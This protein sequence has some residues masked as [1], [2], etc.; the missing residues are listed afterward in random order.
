MT[1]DNRQLPHAEVGMAREQQPYPPPGQWGGRC[2]YC[3]GTDP[4]CGFC[5][6]G[7]PLDSQDDWNRMWGRILDKTSGR[8][9]LNE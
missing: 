1:S 9:G 6:N 5:D 2:L 4:D 8:E 7:K 3:D